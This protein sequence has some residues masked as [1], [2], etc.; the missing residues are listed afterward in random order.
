VLSGFGEA[1]RQG[2]P[3]IGGFCVSYIIGQHESRFMGYFE[4]RRAALESHE[5]ST[6]GSYRT[7]EFQDRVRGGF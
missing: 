7:V 6:D 4:I 2:V 1:L 5:T 3:D